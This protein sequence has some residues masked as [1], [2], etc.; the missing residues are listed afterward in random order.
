MAVLF[1]R[2]NV[3]VHDTDDAD[4]EIIADYFNAWDKEGARKLQI[5]ATAR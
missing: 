4:M 1:R 2:F 3:N 5:T